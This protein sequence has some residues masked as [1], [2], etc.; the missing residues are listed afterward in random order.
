M[1]E[2]NGPEAAE[3]GVSDEGAEEREERSDADPCVV[4]VSGGWSRLVQFVCEVH[5]Q[6]S[7]QA[8]EGKPLG[9]LH[10]FIGTEI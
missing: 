6:I 4:V 1:M 7:I 3:E 10:N 8:L 2:A 5:D 9:H